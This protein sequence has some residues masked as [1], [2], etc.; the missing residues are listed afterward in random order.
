[1][2]KSGPKVQ[3]QAEFGFT[4]QMLILA[5]NCQIWPLL[6]FGRTH[7]M[8]DI[9]IRNNDDSTEELGLKMKLPIRLP[10]SRT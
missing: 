4:V 7:K 1:M 8:T 3:G 10:F 6:F 2:Y 9:Q 5:K